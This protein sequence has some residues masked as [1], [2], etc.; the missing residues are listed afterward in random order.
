[1]TPPLDCTH[2]RD[3]LIDDHRGRLDPAAIA[4][5]AAHLDGCDDCRHEDAVER[6]LTEQ[7]EQRLPQYAAPLALKRRLATQVSG[8][9]RPAPAGRRVWRWALAATAAALLIGGLGLPWL[10]APD[11]RQELAAE[12]VNDHLRLLART[13]PLDVESGDVHQVRPSF[14]GRLDFAPVVAFGGDAEFPLR[15]STVEYFLDRRAA[16]VVYGRRLH[17]VTLLVFRA[18]G[19]PWPRGAGTVATQERGFNVRLWRAQGLGYAL[20]SDLDA[21]ELARLA[22][23]LGG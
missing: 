23:R 15:G 7:L 14:A 10:A 21:A 22:T 4:A 2:A 5:L 16:V 8:A 12:A 18:D 20:V 19:L 9:P 6:V 3:L 11:R 1:M 13:T 17:T